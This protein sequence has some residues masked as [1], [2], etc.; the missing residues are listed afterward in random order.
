MKMALTIEQAM[1]HGLASHR[2]GNLQEAERL[3]RVILKI[4]PGHPGANHNLGLIAVSASAAE[5]ALPLF[6][7]A[8]E[9]NPQ[10]E[11]FW[12]SYID[13]LIRMGMPDSAKAV[14]SKLKKL[15]LSKKS[16]NL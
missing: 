6:T 7:T 1:E 8:L 10:V 15:D 12:L 13:V 4:Q 5:A 11:Q 16:W 14:L 2:E 3:Y 9:I